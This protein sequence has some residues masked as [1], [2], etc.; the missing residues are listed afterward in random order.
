MSEQEEKPPILKTWTNVY[1]LVIGS[2]VLIIFLL[3]LFTQ[4]YK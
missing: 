4:S 2:L 3:Y 1:V